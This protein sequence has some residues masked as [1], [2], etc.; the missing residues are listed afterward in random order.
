MTGR[1]GSIT[2]NSNQRVAKPADAPASAEMRLPVDAGAVLIQSSR[3]QRVE[4]HRAGVVAVSGAWP[5]ACAGVA[6]GPRD[7]I[8]VAA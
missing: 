7:S 3:G 4:A 2:S 1:G 8:Q 6:P 5:E